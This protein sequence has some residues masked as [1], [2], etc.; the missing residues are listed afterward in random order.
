MPTLGRKSSCLVRVLWR[1]IILASSPG[2]ICRPPGGLHRPAVCT[3][4][5]TAT[6]AM[7]AVFPTLRGSAGLRACP[8]QHPLE[9]VQ[10]KLRN[11]QLLSLLLL[12]TGVRAD[13]DVIRLLGHGA[14][15]LA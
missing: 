1:R 10:G 12:G 5:A 7:P 8:S 13:H 4:G 15:T 3:N 9:I 14:T 2:N 6:S 11:A